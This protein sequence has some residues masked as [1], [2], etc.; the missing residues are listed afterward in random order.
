MTVDLE[1]FWPLDP[2]LSEDYWPTLARMRNECPVHRS[3]AFE[4]FWVLTKYDDVWQVARDYETFI[5]GKGVSAV[6]FEESRVRPVP[7][8]ADPPFQR[9]LRKAL[10]PF[11]APRQVELLEPYIR[12]VAGELLDG[13]AS[14]G[15]C[16]FM[17]DFSIH[18]PARVFFEAVLGLSDADV[19]KVRAWADT[20]MIDPH[21]SGRAWDE[22]GA[23][24]QALC[25][26]RRHKGPRGDGDVID[27]L[28]AARFEGEP[29][30]DYTLQGV[31]VNI[32]L[33]GL[34]TTAMALG[35]ILYRVTTMPEVAAYVTAPDMTS[36][37]LAVAVEE[38]LR[39]ET[40]QPSIA[41]VASRDV[42]IDG[43]LIRAGDRVVL[44]YGSGNRDGDMFP[45]ADELV[46]D[47]PLE[48]NRHMTFGSGMHRCLGSN[49]ARTEIRVALEEIFARMTD[50]ELD[51]HEVRFRNAISRG[52]ETLHLRFK[53]RA[54]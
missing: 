35:N 9:T 3:K 23:W 26:D 18:M 13:F 41:R 15:S 28:L 54:R 17:H 14:R 29:L 52:P 10:D 47:R 31:I 50:I 1:H 32:T 8:M 44:F 33:G 53:E 42:E 48:E 40:P 27:A 49:L 7:A 20:M 46:L 11:F 21:N 30:S 12:K 51:Q 19:A 38:F 2:A 36:E 16:E 4:G 22:F 39:Y 25:D 34:E 37:K 24:G 5:S 6:P 43:H 45:R